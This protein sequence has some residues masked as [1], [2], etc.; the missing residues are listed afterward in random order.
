[1]AHDDWGLIDDWGL[2][3][4]GGRTGH[5]THTLPCEPGWRVIGVAHGRASRV[6]CVIGWAVL[7]GDTIEGGQ[8]IHP[9]VA[10]RDGA[11]VHTIG[12]GDS[13]DVLLAPGEDLTF[14]VEEGVLDP[15]E[16]QD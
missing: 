3:D 11:Y 16:S 14:L 1:M 13:N 4:D 7:E 5:I 2:T 12:Y 8:T 6:V 10:N 15:G 9:I